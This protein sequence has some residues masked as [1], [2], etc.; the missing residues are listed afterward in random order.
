MTLADVVSELVAG[1]S[2]DDGLQRALRRLL[3]LT[4]ARVGA[5]AFRPERGDA[6]LVTATSGRVPGDVEDWLGQRLAGPPVRGLRLTR[7]T[8]PGWPGRPVLLRSPL[9]PARRARAELALLGRLS[10]ATLPHDLPEEL[11]RAVEQAWRHYRGLLRLRV[12]TEITR[13]GRS[14]EPLDAVYRVFAEG[15]AGLVAFESIGVSLID[16]A[17]REFTIVDLP[18]RTLDL[19]LRRD[20]RMPLEGTLLAQVAASGAPLRV[21]DLTTAAVPPRSRE[22]LAS[23]GYRSA[24]LVPL[25]AREMVVGAVTLT[26]RRPSAFDDADLEA[27]AGLALPL[28]SAIEQ[29]RL[30]EESR[31]H[32]DETRALLQAGRAVTASLDV[33]ETIRVILDEAR[34][35]LGVES[36]SLATLDP[37]SGVLTIVAS[38]DL[39]SEMLT[40]IQLRAGE[41][42]TGRAVSERGPVQSPD[43]FTDAR[44]HY[45]DIPRRTRFRSMLAVPLRVGERI[46]GT[47]SVFR[48]DVHHFSASEEELLVALADQ[49][50]IAL[51]HARLYT[52]LEGMVAE[53]TQELDAQKRFVEVVLETMPLGVF[54]VDPE[55]R[56]VRAN[57]HAARVLG[58]GDPLGA[59]LPGLVPAARAGAVEALARRVF[60]E[61]Q[62]SVAE[63]EMTIA[64]EVKVLR[65]TAAPIEPA[66]GHLVVLVEDV[67][68]A[69]R[70]ARQMLLTERLTT[71]GRLAA[72]VAHELNNPLATIAGCAESL[73]AR[74]RESALAKLAAMDEFRQY[75]GL[76]EEEAYRCKEITGSLLHFVREPGSRRAAT[77]LNGLVMKT[78]D[79]L[80]HQHRFKDR[81]F[82]TALDPGLPMV[83]VNE[84]QL[85]QVFLGIAANALEAMAG[86]GTL[87]LRSRRVRDEVEIEFEDEG[88]GI[89]DEVL[90]RIFDAFFT[91]KPPGQ[92]TGLGLA[93]AQGIVTDHGGRIEVTSRVGKGSVFRVVLPA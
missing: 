50:A 6:I 64:D 86:E 42:I 65:L 29:R 71:T 22:A 57:R 36:C 39:P 81:R 89:S 67:T 87:H 53:R 21:D 62:V 70:L 82:T 59:L 72:G 2:M 54:V 17:G 23:R 63:E 41:G 32:A 48:R 92:G 12:S 18:A 16:A 43:L 44:V 61:R 38:L 4:G 88:P 55:L 19:G 76:I 74:S 28:A 14:G 10:R 35:V 27:V 46:I 93:I 5:L 66:A 31:R 37:A 52:Q 15:V 78:I 91:T 77:D 3:T 8:P 20:T 24:L 47:V 68:L 13:R 84:G 69:V 51:E 80:S 34:R 75:L 9:G 30:H 33:Q 58:C 60:A 11:G 1:S 56:V 25:V 40:Q 7:V 73:L 79:L 45:P 49:A 85:R 90:G 83:T 26:S